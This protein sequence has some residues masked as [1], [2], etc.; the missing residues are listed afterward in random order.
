ML[1]GGGGSQPSN[2]LSAKTVVFY[3]PPKLL[4]CLF[5]QRSG[6]AAGGIFYNV[7]P[8]TAA[9]FCFKN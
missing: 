7:P 8:G 6:I 1:F 9:R 2:D 4:I 5:A 3:L